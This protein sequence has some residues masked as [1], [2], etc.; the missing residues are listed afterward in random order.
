MKTRNIIMI[1]VV[2]TIFVTAG[3]LVAVGVATHTEEGLLTACQTADGR[4]DYEGDCEEVKW[5]PSQFPLQVHA[6]TTNP[7]PPSDPES[8]TRSVISLVNSRLGFRA[9]QWTDDSS[10]ADISVRIGEAQVVG[11][12]MGDAN[13][14]ASHFVR[15]GSLRCEIRTWNTGTVEMLDKVLTH[16]MGHGLGLAHDPDYEGSAMYPTVTPDGARLTRLRITDHDRGLLR[17]LYNQ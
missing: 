9:L 12:S 4:F 2:A 8:A 7:H 13:G 17:E 15:D 6:T 10:S 5:D 11:S 16:E 3:V 1:V 14:D